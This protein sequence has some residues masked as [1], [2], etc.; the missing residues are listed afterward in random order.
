MVV[1]RIEPHGAGAWENISLD[2]DE[3]PPEYG[4]GQVRTIF[5]SE[6]GKVTIY[7][8]RRDKDIGQLRALK[9]A[10]ARTFHCDVLLDGAVTIVDENG[11]RTD[12][13]TGEMLTYNGADEGRW[14][15]DGPLLK[16]AISVEQ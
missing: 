4:S 9:T 1:K 3:T 12:A 7:L 13:V 16:L 6:D 15:A 10:T 14:L 11:H 5:Q 8:Y 2:G